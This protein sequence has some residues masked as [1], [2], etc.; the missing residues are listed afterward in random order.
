MQ[1]LGD[2]FLFS[3]SDLGSFLACEHLTQLELAVVLREDRRP[4]Y[5]NAYADLLRSK[6]DEHERAFL[7][8]IRVAGHDVAEVGLDAARDFETGARRTVEAMKI[9]AAYV[10]QAVFYSDGWRG[11]ADFLERVDQPSALGAWSYQVLDTKLARHPRPEHALQ[12]SFYSQALEQI[13]QVA[14]NL[15]HVVLGTRER[16]PIRLADVNAYFRR[17]RERFTAAVKARPMTGPYPCDYCSFCDFRVACDQRLEQEDHVVRV[18]GIHRDQVKRLFAGGINTL[19]ALAGAPPSLSAVKMAVSTFEG[20]REQ[21]GLQLIRQ[22]TGRLE[23]RPRATEV[24]RGFGAL[25]RRSAGDVIFDL[26]GHPFFEPARGLEYLFG[27]LLV[28]GD[29]PRYQAFWAHVNGLPSRA[30]RGHP[31]GA[32]AAR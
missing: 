13:Q 31:Y 30:T 16:L 3:P 18:A 2:R 32:S 6:G 17:V 26:E 22:R 12:L 7:E 25:P 23:W 9:G 19:A 8:A 15:A 1:H 29:E 21:A 14:P 24:G 20:L 27:I 4:S 11:I 28:D 5:E 10:Y